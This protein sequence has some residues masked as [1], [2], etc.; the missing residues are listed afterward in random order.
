MARTSLAFSIGICP[1]LFLLAGPPA[2]GQNSVAEPIALGPTTAA[3]LTP[4]VDSAE[5]YLNPLHQSQWIGLN[6]SRG[7]EGKLVAFDGAGEL[8]PRTAV[9]VLL[10]QKG[11]AVSRDV[12]NADGIFKFNNIPAGT[13]SFVARSQ[14]TYATFGIHILPVGSGSPSSFEVCASTTSAIHAKE[15]FKDNWVPSE[16]Y[17]PRVFDKDPVA[18]KRVIS[19]S[20]Q[21]LLQDGDLVG[22]VSRPGIP[23][24]QQNLTGNVAHV[25]QAGR[26]IAA[27]P[28]ARDGKFRLMNLPSG[29]YDLVVMGKDG[30]A[31]IG[32]EAVGASPL[33]NKRV[34]E[35]EFVSFVK[36]NNTLNVELADPADLGP[37]FEEI[38]PFFDETVGPDFGQ[39]VMGGGFA[40]PGGGFGGGGGGFGG[41]GLGGGGLGGGGGGLGGA[42]GGIGGLLGIAGLA[43]GVAA[44]SNNDDDFFNPIPASLIAP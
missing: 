6:N 15:L 44:L 29:I 12:T 2:L 25:F 11:K 43:V 8:A 23:I 10:L 13:Y 42:G 24:S 33:A 14:F 9:E 38:P 34:A 7:V 32:F 17:N 26:S 4:L 31:V 18:D 41:G 28:V 36:L 39:P 19:A 21:V 37:T 30:G 1:V 27:A 5:A 35:T 16:T 40:A 20:T 3:E 22:Q